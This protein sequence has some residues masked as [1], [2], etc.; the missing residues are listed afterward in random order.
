M[1]QKRN[2][3]FKMALKNIVDNFSKSVIVTFQHNS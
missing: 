2:C 3:N 1:Q